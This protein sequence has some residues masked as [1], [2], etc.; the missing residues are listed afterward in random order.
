MLYSLKRFSKSE[1][2]QQRMKI[3]KFYE[4]YGEKATKEAFG[5]DRKVISRWRKRLKEAEGSLTGLIPHSTRPYKVRCSNVSPK[6]I[7]FIKELRERHPRLG[8]EK[9]KPLLDKYCAENG[10]KSVSESTVGNIIK[11]HKFFYQKSG[12]IYHDP[13]SKW[14]QNSVKKARRLKI[15]HPLKPEDFGHIVADTVERVTDGVKDYFYNAIDAKLRFAL[16]LNYKRLTSRNMKDF[17]HRFKS[18]YP[19]VIKSWQTDNGSENLGEFDDELKRDRIPHYFSY[20]RCPKINTYIERYNRTLQ[21]EFIDNNLDVI[22]DKPLF[23]KRLADYLIFYNTQRPHK[24]LGLK[25]PI[26]YLIE[27]GGMSQKSLTY[28]KNVLGKDI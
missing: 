25:S 20:P 22:Y 26:D 14:A 2:A 6:I 13:N 23:H 15:K 17:Y 18:V 10:L 3:I 11:R 24:S 7:N 1:V 5:A 8:K 12:R 16:T 4:E 28:T 21:E 19:Y 9:I 27:N